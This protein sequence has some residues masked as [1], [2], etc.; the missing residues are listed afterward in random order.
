MRR[1]FL[2]TLGLLCAWTA[3]AKTVSVE[4]DKGKTIEKALADNAGALEIVVSGTCSENVLIDRDGVTITGAAGATLTG[5]P[6]VPPVAAIT[7]LS[8][9]GV[10]IRT[11]A[12]SGGGRHGIFVNRGSAVEISGVTSSN[13]TSHGL[14]VIDDSSARITDSTFNDNTGD[15]I[16]NWGG[17]FVTLV[18]TNTCNGNGR[19]GI[20]VSASVLNSA[21]ASPLTLHDN[22]YTGLY[23]QLSASGQL[24]LAVDVLGSDEGIA[25]YDGAS[26]A[27]G[28]FA[29]RSNGF[30]GV[31]VWNNSTFES[32]GASATIEDNGYGIW[33]EDDSSFVRRGATTFLNNGDAAMYAEGS[34]VYLRAANSSGNGGGFVSRNSS[35]RARSSPK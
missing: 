15:G 16:G 28:G 32:G 24:G 35:V 3:A 21:G 18:G 13:N 5:I 26:L 23:L 17:S 7:V 19:A 8:A 22:G 10:A 31:T 2:V 20:I 1:L 30:S 25:V 34:N 4:C 14:L 11:L 27:L 12:V 6:A 29:S 9:R 33:V